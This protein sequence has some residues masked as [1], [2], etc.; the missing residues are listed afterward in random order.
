[1]GESLPKAAKGKIK[2]SKHGRSE[3]RAEKYW[4]PNYRIAV[5][6]EA[7]ARTGGA[8][9]EAGRKKSVVQR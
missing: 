3:I 5:R 4:W 7:Q 2:K 1:M 9:L 6:R 8:H